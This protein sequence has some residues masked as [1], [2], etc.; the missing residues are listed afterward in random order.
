MY[1]YSYFIYKNKIKSL[2]S[3]CFNISFASFPPN[4]KQAGLLKKKFTKEK[5]E[6]FKSYNMLLF[7]YLF[8]SRER[9]KSTVHL[10]GSHHAA[11]TSH[12]SVQPA[13]ILGGT[14]V[15]RGYR[16]A[17]RIPTKRK[18]QTQAPPTWF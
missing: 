13:R 10:L 12:P 15:G 16:H 8:I 17:Q 2:F 4:T 7:I 18:I 6:N 1:L 5:K 9:E 11:N 3:F 14:W